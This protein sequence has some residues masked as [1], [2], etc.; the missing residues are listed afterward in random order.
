MKL[1]SSLPGVFG[2]IAP[3][4]NL[5]MLRR[6]GVLD[7]LSVRIQVSSSILAE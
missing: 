2:S 1:H 3:D 4:T 5:D 7:I 6:G